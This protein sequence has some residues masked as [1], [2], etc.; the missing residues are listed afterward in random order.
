V[1][2]LASVLLASQAATGGRPSHEGGSVISAESTRLTIADLLARRAARHPDKTFLKW[3]H[4][5]FSYGQVEELTTRYANA[6]MSCGVCPR[7]HVAL[8]LEN[9]PD[10]Y[11]TLWG[12]G[13]IG[14]V[15]V[16]LNTAARGDMLHYY[17]AQSDVEWI[18]VS[19]EL[20]DRISAPASSLPK[21]KG[22]FR[23]STDQQ[24]GALDALGIP[25]ADLTVLRSGE[26]SAVRVRVLESDLQGIFFTSGTTGPSKG[27]LSPQSQP[28]SIARQTA[29]SFGYGPEDVL[30]TCLPLFHVNAL[31][32]TSY[33][34]M[35]AGATVALGER[36]SA[37]RFW[38]EVRGYGATAISS[39]GA[40]TN[41]LLKQPESE[42]DRKHLVR[43]A[44]IVPTGREVVE[45][46]ESRFGVRVVS[47]FGA[48][49]T[50][51]VSA[52]GPDRDPGAP[53][54]SAGRVTDFAQVRIVDDDGWPVPAATS[55]E[56]LVRPNGAGTMMRGYYKMTEATQTVFRDLW[57]HT[58]DRGCIDAD[59]YLYFVDRIKE[60]IRRRG[61][62]ISAHE[63]EVLIGKH[64]SVL[65]VAAIPLPS[66]MSEDE[67]MV[68]VVPRPGQ[69]IDPA[70]LIL[71]R[72][73]DMPYFML[74][75]FVKV[76]VELP[77]T[78]SERIEKY[79]LRQWAIENPRDIWDR[80]KAG[81]QVER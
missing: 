50:F 49:E 63:V 17:L 27:V 24:G 61:E 14:A 69:A 7:D 57:F 9:G 20:E 81:L 53:L 23:L 28:I 12:L 70:E 32:Y 33:A 38:D 41:I 48:T 18:V 45:R 2:L 37:S 72:S 79:K 74:P 52:L 6:F 29:Q 3:H 46:F 68:F 15:S 11:W 40:M 34:A 62:N 78:P 51:L 65:E 19:P 47:G 31:W 77:K 25:V 66:E 22:A 80:D 21:L 73:Q 76:V 26:A 10:F 1:S 5:D 58:G 44:F 64:P 43:K 59:G 55:G 30:Y 16:P 35:W 75:R 42:R 8:F 39:L 71:S 36:F 4:E 54:E 67:V 56:I 60:A 13:K